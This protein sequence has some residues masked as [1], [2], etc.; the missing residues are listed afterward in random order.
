MNPDVKGTSGE[1]LGSAPHPAALRRAAE[2]A[3]PADKAE[4][5]PKDG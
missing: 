4:Q 3:A 2:A 1:G 5:E